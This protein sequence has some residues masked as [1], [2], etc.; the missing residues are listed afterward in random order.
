MITFDSDDYIDEI[1]EVMVM[2]SKRPGIS[3]LDKTAVTWA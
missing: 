2:A 1:K 3:I